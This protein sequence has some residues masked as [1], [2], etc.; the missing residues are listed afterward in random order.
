[1][2][3]PPACQLCYLT[4]HR[5]VNRDHRQ[6]RLADL[7]QKRPIEQPPITQSP[8]PATWLVTQIG[9][10]SIAFAGRI[11]HDAIFSRAHNSGQP[12]LISFFPTSHAGSLRDMLRSSLNRLAHHPS[13]TYPRRAPWSNCY[14]CPRGR[15]QQTVNLSRPTIIPS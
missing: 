5:S 1:M 8:V 4:A 14:A 9:T 12:P 13:V 2:Q 11:D 6:F 15:F 3:A 10:P 7:S